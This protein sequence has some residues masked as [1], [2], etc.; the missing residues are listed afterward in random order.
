[1]LNHSK[2]HLGYRNRTGNETFE[3]TNKRIHR[4]NRTFWEKKF[5][6]TGFFGGV[7]AILLIN[8]RLP[9]AISSASARAN[10]RAGSTLIRWPGRDYDRWITRFNQDRWGSKTETKTHPTLISSSRGENLFLPMPRAA[11]VS[12]SSLRVSQQPKISSFP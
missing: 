9:P 4:S 6:K 10:P 11:Y 8:K 3:K 1:L 7:E 12:S 2:P 5:C